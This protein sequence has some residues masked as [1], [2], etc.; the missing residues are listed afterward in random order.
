MSKYKITLNGKSY[1]IE[2]EA[3]KEGLGEAIGFD[4]WHDRLKKEL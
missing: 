3:L 2:V 1:E 4:F